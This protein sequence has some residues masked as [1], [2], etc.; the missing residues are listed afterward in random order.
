MRIVAVNGWPTPGTNDFKAINPPVLV[1]TGKERIA[2]MG[3]RNILSPCMVPGPQSAS[4]CSGGLSC[5][6]MAVAVIDTP[7]LIRS[8]QIPIA[9][10]RC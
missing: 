8:V 9:R 2:A 5:G 4:S 10:R 6:A 7:D 3:Q 1:D